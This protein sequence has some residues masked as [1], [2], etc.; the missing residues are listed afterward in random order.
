MI[1]VTTWTFVI[2]FNFC[3]LCDRLKLYYSFNFSYL[4]DCFKSSWNLLTHCNI[5]TLIF[6]L[7]KCI[8]CFFV[9]V[10]ILKSLDWL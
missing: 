4:H 5:Y 9:S 1:Y 8:M 3:C 7:I 2:G 10:L 6:F